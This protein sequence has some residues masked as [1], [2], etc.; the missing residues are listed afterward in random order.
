MI[1]VTV[2]VCAPP[3]CCIKGLDS[4]LNQNL[5]ADLNWTGFV[6]S[7]W[8]AIRGDGYEVGTERGSGGARF[9]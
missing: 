5:K 8:G 7:D 4:S 3:W 1:T 2:T 6:T 9:I